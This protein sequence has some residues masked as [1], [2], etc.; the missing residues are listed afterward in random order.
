MAKKSNFI[1]NLL[2]TASAVAVLAG[3]VN[4]AVAAERTTTATAGVVINGGVNMGG[5]FNNGDAIKIHA[6]I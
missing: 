6:D 4:T 3:G 1:K 5:A 2:T